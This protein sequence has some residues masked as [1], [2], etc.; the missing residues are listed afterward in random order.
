MKATQTHSDFGDDPDSVVYRYAEE[1]ERALARG[2]RD[3]VNVKRR[4]L[5]NKLEDY[6]RYLCVN[7][8]PPGNPQKHRHLRQVIRRA[9][10]QATNRFKSGKTASSIEKEITR[11]TNEANEHLPKGIAEWVVEEVAIAQ[12]EA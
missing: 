7:P 12:E 10:I 4:L 11:N 3:L 5:F 6:E 8:D 9:S 2:D 1:Y